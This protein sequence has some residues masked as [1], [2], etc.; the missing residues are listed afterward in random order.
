MLSTSERKKLK[1]TKALLPSFSSDL[2]KYDELYQQYCQFGYTKGLCDEFATVFVDDCKKPATEDVILAA[3]LYSKI[4]D[5]NNTEFYLDML[6][7]KKM[8]SD[9]RYSYCLEKLAI[10]SKQ[11]N[12]RDAEDFRTENINFI[13]TH[14]QKKKT[15]QEQADMYIVLALVDCA[16]KKYAEAFKLLNFGYKPKGRNDVKL[17]QILVTAVYIYA[18]AGD[19]DGVAAAVENAKSCLKL[20]DHFEF[21][22]SKEY[23]ENLIQ[24]ASEGII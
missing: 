16:A 23:Y 19:E 22:W 12:W 24:S 21:D 6:E 18:C 2:K 5:Y 7:E 13:Q 15:T 17:L 8:G 9:D 4:F 10:L 11:K 3:S 1:F 14:A 20:F